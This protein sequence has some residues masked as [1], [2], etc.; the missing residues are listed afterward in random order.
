MARMDM[1]I[2]ICGHAA[3]LPVLL[4]AWSP[5]EA[6]DNDLLPPVS[7]AHAASGRASPRRGC[8]VNLQGRTAT[9]SAPLDRKVLGHS[10]SRS[11]LCHAIVTNSGNFADP[12]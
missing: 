11:D 12:V 5:S 10:A 7:R 4:S 2:E 1:R 9:A 8:W 3:A 6:R